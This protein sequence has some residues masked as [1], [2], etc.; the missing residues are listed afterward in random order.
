M[1]YVCN[2]RHDCQSAPKNQIEQCHAAQH[3]AG[4][5]DPWM[6]EHL[7]AL[8]LLCVVLLII[9]IAVHAILHSIDWLS[10][11]GKRR[12]SSVGFRLAA[13]RS[14]LDFPAVLFHT[15]SDSRRGAR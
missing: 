10:L 14:R 1:P 15:S 5:Q 12:G 3:H 13:R 2:D 7:T 8:D 11:V 6:L 4:A 9:V